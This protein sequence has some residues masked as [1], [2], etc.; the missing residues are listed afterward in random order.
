M[1]THPWGSG[2]MRTD[3]A[4]PSGAW[5]STS[6]FPGDAN[7]SWVSRW[8]AGRGKRHRLPTPR[9]PGTTVRSSSIGRSKTK[10][11]PS[12]DADKGTILTP[13]VWCCNE[14]AQ[15]LPWE[16]RRDWAE[17]CVCTARGV[18]GEKVRRGR[19]ALLH[20]AG[21]YGDTTGL[22]QTLPSALLVDKNPSKAAKA[23]LCPLRGSQMSQIGCD[24]SQN[25]GAIYRVCSPN[26]ISSSCCSK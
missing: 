25:R 17:D 20:D 26:T 6:V 14:G 11:P 13:W 3:P 19:V 5:G 24:G 10:F 4:G 18:Y 8:E 15:R 21:I 7:A 12:K 1:D 9:A 16:H 22:P 23:A 2:W